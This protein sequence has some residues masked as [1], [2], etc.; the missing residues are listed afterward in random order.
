MPSSPGERG[1]EMPL[2]KHTSGA[3]DIATVVE[4]DEQASAA[5][6]S[7]TLGAAGA[8]YAQETADPHPPGPGLALT[9]LRSRARQIASGGGKESGS[10]GVV[11][12]L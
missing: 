10:P 12:A 6:M 3:G 7:D 5:A 8:L 1:D 9:M 4:D 2:G 11:M